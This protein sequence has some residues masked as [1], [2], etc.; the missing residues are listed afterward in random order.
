MNRE[1]TRQEFEIV[2]D[3]LFEAFPATAAPG[4]NGG[5][6]AQ[7][8]DGSGDGGDDED[9][10]FTL[11]TDVICGFPGETDADFEETAQMVRGK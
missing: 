9:D 11:A 6:G 1:Y 5:G 10:G 4:V 8:E 2:A 3:S 7:E